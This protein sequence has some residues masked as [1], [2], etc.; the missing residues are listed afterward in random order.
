[1]GRRLSSRCEMSE[2]REEKDDRIWGLLVYAAVP[3]VFY[4]VLHWAAWTTRQSDQ[5]LHSAAIFLLVGLF[6][7]FEER[8]RLQ[9]SAQHDRCSLGL[10]A[11]SFS[12]VAFQL[13]VPWPP[14]L[15]AAL[16]LAVASIIRFLLGNSAPALNRALGAGFFAFLLLAM[17]L[18]YFDWPLRSLA[19]EWAASLIGWLGHGTALYLIS[20]QQP[21]LVLEVDGHPFIVAAEC[22]GFGLLSASLLLVILLAVY[23]RLLLPDVLL[24][25]L[26]AVFVSF[27]SNLTRIIIIVELAPHVENY[28][29]MHETVGIL[30]FYAALALLSWL[31]WSWPQKSS[32]SKPEHFDKTHHD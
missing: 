27:V 2:I 17:A 25:L 11:A 28:Y 29:L 9:L 15:L 22:N 24:S 8:P 18:P 23:R 6:L 12:L 3:F 1:M 16:S 32:T 20:A 31:I 30:C 7:V 13:L 10:I 5:L 21:A 26:T 14:L 4:P 19:G